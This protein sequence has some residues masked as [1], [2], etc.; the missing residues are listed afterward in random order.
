MDADTF[1][2][3]ADKRVERHVRVRTRMTTRFNPS[4]LRKQG[5]IRLTTFRRDGTPVATPVHVAA[6]G[7]RAFFRTWDPTGKLKRIRRND[8][9][10]VAPSTVTGTPTGPTMPARA[11]ILEGKDAQHVAELLGRKYG[12]LHSWLFPTVHRIMGWRTVHLELVPDQR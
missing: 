7:N 4:V 10:L 5:T 6:E 3:A 11:R 9:V 1:C 2:P 8:R 12:F